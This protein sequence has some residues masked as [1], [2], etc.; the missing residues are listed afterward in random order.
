MPKIKDKAIEVAPVVVVAKKES[1]IPEGLNQTFKGADGKTYKL[2]SVLG[3]GDWWETKGRGKLTLLTHEAVEKIAK[4]AGLYVIKYDLLV[5]PTVYNNMTVVMSP[6]IR[7]K[8]GNMLSPELGEASRDNL[9]SKGKSY[10]HAMAQK[11][12]FDRTVLRGLGIRGLL[13]EDE[14]PQD[15]K[16][17]HPME[18]L[19]LDEQKVI[20]PLVTQLLLA[21]TKVQ[22]ANFN[23]VMPEKK[24]ELKLNDNQLDFVRRLYKKRIG[25][26]EK[27]NWNEHE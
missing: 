23:R 25:D 27:V 10:P 8:D 7:D 11:R 1:D 3:E 5:E 12:A 9:G 22:L 2:K 26:L 13:S 15:N 6:E 19:S 18:N 20:A 17:D 4:I 24:N 14:L 16:I 21:S